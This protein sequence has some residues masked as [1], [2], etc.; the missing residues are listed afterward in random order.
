MPNGYFIKCQMENASAGP[1]PK[2]TPYARGPQLM[3]T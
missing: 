2:F 1:A 3:L